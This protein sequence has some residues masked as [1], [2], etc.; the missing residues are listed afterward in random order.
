M[1][2]N[3]FVALGTG[4]LETTLRYS[5][6]GRFDGVLILFLLSDVLLFVVLLCCGVVQGGAIVER[7][8]I[9]EALCLCVCPSIVWEEKQNG[10]CHRNK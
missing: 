1:V 6:C 2:R 8:K 7:K 9:S 10:Q 4:P 5:P 3:F